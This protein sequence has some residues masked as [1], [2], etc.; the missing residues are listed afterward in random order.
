MSGTPRI[1]PRL[2]IGVFLVILGVLFTLENLGYAD[3]EHYFE[4]W[5]LLFVVIGW[6]KWVQ[7]RSNPARLAAATWGL[8][9]VWLI[10]HNL[11]ILPYSFWDFWPLLLILIGAW[12]IW[13]TMERSE[14]R[15]STVDPSSTVSALA[16]WSG[17][18]RKS[19]SADFRGG[20]LTAIMGGCEVDLT[21]A[22]I[23]E[24]EAVLDLFAVWGGI[25]VRVPPD[26][27]IVSQVTAFMGAY[28]ENAQPAPADSTQRLVLRGLAIMGAIEVKN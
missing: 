19:S 23:A 4:F 15:Q 22:R 5:P 25:E 3:V 1:T 21:Q 10:L 20:E 12:V 18:D 7:A 13:Q 17:A 16:I 11:D 14:R 6:T 27:K 24:G 26:W 2:L 9:G 28:E 8:V